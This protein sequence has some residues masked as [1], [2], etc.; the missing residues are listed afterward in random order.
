MLVIMGWMEEI[1]MEY[2]S[3]SDVATTQEERDNREC[4]TS[5]MSIRE[6][7]W[8]RLPSIMNELEYGIYRVIMFVARAAKWSAEFV[9]SKV[10][11]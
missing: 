1:I 7:G 10:K 2:L 6:V 9:V 8:I 3:A 5:L 11:G 4:Q